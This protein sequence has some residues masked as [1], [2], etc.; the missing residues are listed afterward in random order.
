[1][2]SPPPPASVKALLDESAQE[3]DEG[4]KSVF[5]AF[6]ALFAP[7][8][9]PQLVAACL[10]QSPLSTEDALDALARRSLA[11]REPGVSF[12][13]LHD[14]TFAYVRGLFSTN[15]GDYRTTVAAVQQYVKQYAAD[16]DLIELDLPNLLGAAAIAAGPTLV[17]IVA[18]LVMGGYPEPR[19]PS[20]MDVRGH[21][22]ELLLRL[23]DAIAAARQMAPANAPL[24][25]YLLGK[26]GN[27]PSRPW[28]TQ[29]RPR[30]LRRRPRTG[31][32]PQPQSRASQRDR[33]HANPTRPPR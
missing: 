24:A 23:D 18:P 14:L 7:G 2:A 17:S 10:Q 27:A 32:Q 1:M 33:P 4:A 20:Y 3:L 28:R 25:H 19:Q 22:L 9:T 30:R 11:V 31:A 26:R 13:R 6:G 21:T 16:F 15:Q 29:P 12:Y 8:A 5:Q